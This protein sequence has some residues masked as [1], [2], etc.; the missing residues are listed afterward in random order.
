MTEMMQSKGTIRENLEEW[1]FK[2][3][4][5]LYTNGSRLV[6]LFRVI[7]VLEGMGIDVDKPIAKKEKE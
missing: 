6:L 7:Q 3:S 4:E 1:S 2:D 5:E